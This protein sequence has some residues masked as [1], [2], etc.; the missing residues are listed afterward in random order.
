MT[1]EEI[2]ETEILDKEAFQYLSEMDVEVKFFM[3]S[4]CGYLIKKISEG[5]YKVI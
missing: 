3:V 5:N 2:K 1:L 4:M